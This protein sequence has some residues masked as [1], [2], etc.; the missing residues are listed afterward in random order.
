MRKLKH[1]V[2]EDENWV[3]IT[4]N[5]RIIIPKKKGGKRKVVPEST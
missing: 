2:R 4:T 5:D 3:R 1:P